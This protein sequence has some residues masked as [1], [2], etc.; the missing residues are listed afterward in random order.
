MSY[1]RI[2][3]QSESD[4]RVDNIHDK[5][6]YGI[7]I[8]RADLSFEDFIEYLIRPLCRAMGYADATIEEYLGQS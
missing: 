3:L 4:M 6:H 5:E 2:T 1:T 7:E 8:N